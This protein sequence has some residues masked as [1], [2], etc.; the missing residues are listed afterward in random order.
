MKIIG[1]LTTLS[2]VFGGIAPD[3]AGYDVG[4]LTEVS[5]AVALV[6]CPQW[7]WWLCGR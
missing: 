7:L 2:L 6:S 1:I 4:R 3:N 5:P